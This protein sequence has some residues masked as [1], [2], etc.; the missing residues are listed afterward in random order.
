MLMASFDK[1]SF[2]YFCPVC[3][4]L[5][6]WKDDTNI[7]YSIIE[8]GD[9]YGMYKEKRKKAEKVKQLTKRSLK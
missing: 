4:R 2:V 7:M 6:V 3:S 1:E 8:K 5:L 9:H